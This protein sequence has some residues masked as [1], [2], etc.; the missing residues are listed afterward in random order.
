MRLPVNIKENLFFLLAE[1]ASQV[2]NLSVLLE[3][4]S[5]TVGQRILDRHGY[6]YNLKMRIHDACTDIL[7]KG[8][9]NPVDIFSLRAAENIASDL[10][11]I[12]DICHDCVRLSQ[13]LSGKNSV[14][15]Y[16]I[17]ELLQEVSNGLAI[18]ESALEEENT[19]AAIKVGEIE[20]RLDRCYHKLF[21]SQINKL[22]TLKRPENAIT[23]LF[24]AQRIEE[25]GDV[26]QDIA[27]SIVSARL[28]QPMHLDRFRSLKSALSDLGLIEGDI[29]QIAETRSGS[30]ISGITTGDQE[31]GYAAILKD[32]NREK[33]QEE[34]ESVE[35]WH[36]IFPGLAPKI[37][38][39]TKKGKNASLLIEH[40]PGQT[41]EQVL[42]QD[43]K[44]GLDKALKLLFKTLKAVWQETYKKKPVAAHHM[45]QLNKRLSAVLE[46]HPEFEL[47]QQ[48]VCG[49]QINSLS[50]LIEQAKKLEETLSPPFSVYIHGDFNVDNIIIDA[51][52]KKVRFIDLHR[53]SYMDYV[54]DVAV[55]MVSNYR[56]QVLDKKTRDKICHVAEQMYQFASGYAA[57]KQDNNFDLRL[58][59]G[60]ARSFISSTRF[61][62]DKSL[63]G[64]L[65]YRG[66]YL[67]ER[68]NELDKHKTENFRLN[69]RELFR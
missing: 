13:N 27:E 17:V 23:S 33:L 2:A 26:L 18:V 8:K 4:S 50:M 29:E 52:S 6:A 43:D 62:L 45:M 21:N 65:F 67:L 51:D 15:K 12:T 5:V 1:T 22:K 10:E 49:L 38:S 31:D 63:A 20:R 39:Y 58:A 41:F 60:L 34:R 30:G 61:I 68:I 55:F 57:K 64:N 69:I 44:V 19:Q 40:L 42:R 53:S 66:V 14:R 16:P 54:Q 56:L 32:G 36:E 25:M 7:K 11:S 24:I 48:S 59:L 35:S 9:K 3:T 28:G 37:L 46:I 47:N